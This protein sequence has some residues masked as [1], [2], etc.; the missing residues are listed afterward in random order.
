[1]HFSRPRRPPRPS[2]QARPHSP[3]TAVH[4]PHRAPAITASNGAAPFAELGLAVGLVRALA[5]EGYERPTPIQVQ[6]IPPAL[7]GRDVLACAQTGTGKTAAFIL[8]LLHRLALSHGKGR[9]RSLVLTP[10]RELAAQIG[11]RAAAYGRHSGLKYSVIFGGVSQGPQTAALRHGLD[12]LIATPGR[13]LDLMQQGHVDLAGVEVFVLDEADRMLDMGFINDVRRIV[14]K[15][16]KVRQVLLFSATIAPEIRSLSQSLLH[17]PAYV[18]VSP[19]VTTAE[20]VDQVLYFVHKP[21][22]GALLERLLRGP[23]ITRGLVF[24]RTKHGADKVHKQLVR[25]GIAAA[26]IHGNKSQNARNHALDNFRRGNTRV[27][28][29]TDVAARGIDVEGISHVINYDLPNV[30]ES[31]VHRVG[32]TGR[33]GATGSAISFV[34]PDE[35][36]FL[37]GIERLIKRTIPSAEGS[38]PRPPSRAPQA[39]RATPHAHRSSGRN[40][41]RGQPR[42][43]RR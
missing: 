20:S 39:N 14:L 32:R 12:L 33:A 11:E 8:P 1:M 13:L 19:T 26:V 43:R 29:A 2:H 5:H 42:R 15:L 22:K 10:T 6:A 23:Q 17:D 21:E 41:F 40:V 3:A 25:A 27:L 4:R 16:P 24:T 36:E 37:A 7:A 18:A 38:A 28:V 31:Y 35:R 30:S 34:D 9:V